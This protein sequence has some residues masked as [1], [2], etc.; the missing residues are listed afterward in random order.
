MLLVT[1][2]IFSIAAGIVIDKNI[3]A[4]GMVALL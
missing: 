1:S 4:S 2:V 3:N